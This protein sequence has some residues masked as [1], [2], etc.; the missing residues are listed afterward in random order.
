MYSRGLGLA[1]LAESIGGVLCLNADPY[2]VAHA[3]SG[4]SH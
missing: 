2:S 1:N 3:S 4:G